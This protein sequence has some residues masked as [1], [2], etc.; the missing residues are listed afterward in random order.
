M[1]TL[2]PSHVPFDERRCVGIE[3]ARNVREAN[4][5]RVVRRKTIEDLVHLSGVA[6]ASRIFADVEFAAD[7]GNN[8]VEPQVLDA[9]AKFE[10]GILKGRNASRTFRMIEPRERLPEVPRGV[11][12]SGAIDN[13][14]RSAVRMWRNV[15]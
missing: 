1:Q 14:F 2:E 3:R 15:H 10:G 11:E 5:L 4:E 13:L 6:L 12:D 9:E 7:S 8:D